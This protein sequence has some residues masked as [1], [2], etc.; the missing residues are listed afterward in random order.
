MLGVVDVVPDYN[1]MA[2][3]VVGYCPKLGF[4]SITISNTDDYRYM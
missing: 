3:H 4:L 2:V 1:I